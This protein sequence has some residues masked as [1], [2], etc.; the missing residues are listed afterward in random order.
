MKKGIPVQYV[1]GQVD[2]LNLN[3]KINRHVLIP[4]FETEYFVERIFFYLKK[5]KKPI[6]IIDIGAGS[7]CIAIAIKKKFPFAEVYASDIS[8]KALE[9][10]GFNANINQCDIKFI[11]SDLF[12]KISEKFDV[13]VSNP[14]YLSRFDKIMPKVLNYEPKI[15]LFADNKGLEFFEEILKEAK[16]KINVE[17]L[18]AFE[19]VDKQ[20]NKIK[21]IAAKYYP[22]SSIIVEKDLQ[23]RERFIFIE[24]KLDFS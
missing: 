24:K 2:F 6:K 15:A 9:V 3:L 5:R 21:K 1:I 22:Q 7:G 14:P 11:K 23:N 17:G 20:G 10:A 8:K 18:I 12:E 4:R 16:D 13:I 19:I